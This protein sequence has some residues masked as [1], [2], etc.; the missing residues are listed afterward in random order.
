MKISTSI[1]SIQEDIEKI[2]QIDQLPTDFIHLDV[3][4]GKFVPNTVDFRNL[5]FFTKQLD[6]HLMVEDVKKYIDFYE[7]LHPTYITFH[8][9]VGN[10]KE[11]ISYIKEK[12]IKVGLCVKPATPIEDL[13]PYLKEIDLVLVMSVE[14]GF[15][16]QAFLGNTV[17][18]L[19]R[20]KALKEEYGPYLIEVDGGINATTCKW[21]T[22]ADML[23]IGSYI[24]KAPSSMGAI[25]SIKESLRS[26]TE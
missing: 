22:D 7:T 5:S 14:P 2:K 3:M 25:Q 6:V 15:G 8:L 21:C 18:K 4:D 23:V 16:G 19:K 13:L 20:L 10:T 26:G 24:T 9:E 1:L 12:G 17:S 11:L